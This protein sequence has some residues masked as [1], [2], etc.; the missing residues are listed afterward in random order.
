MALPP[1]AP[2]IVAP[3]KGGKELQTMVPPVPALSFPPA[4]DGSEDL[5]QDQQ[6][7]ACGSTPTMDRAGGKRSGQLRQTRARGRGGR[8]RCPREED[9]PNQMTCF[10]LQGAGVVR[11]GLLV[12]DRELRKTRVQPTS[13]KGGGDGAWFREKCWGKDLEQGWGRPR[14]T[15]WTEAAGRDER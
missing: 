15:L 4:V 1:P 12:G 14:P 7:Q 11:P 8:G 5:G 9:S 6:G 10:H 2:G 13:R 3:H